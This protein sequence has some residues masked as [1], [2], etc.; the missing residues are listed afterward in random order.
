MYGPECK[1]LRG[2]GQLWHGDELVAEVEYELRQ[3]ADPQDPVSIRGR[4]FDFTEEQIRALYGRRLTLRLK[5]GE[6][7]SCFFADATGEI[8]FTAHGLRG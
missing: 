6:A 5:S 7:G 1:T 8:I 4:V 2:A 3:S